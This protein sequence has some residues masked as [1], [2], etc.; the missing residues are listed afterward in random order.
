MSAPTTP[1][2]RP[3]SSGARPVA[4]A[5][6][7]V[8]TA[9]RPVA[10]ASRATTSAAPA[11]AVNYTRSTAAA[12]ATSSGPV[13]YTRATTSATSAAPA[14]VNYTRSTA[15]AAPANPQE[16]A[17][18]KVS[19]S[20]T[21][22]A[23]PA[24]PSGAVNY[25]RSTAS[26]APATS[27]EPA[28]ERVSYSR[29]TTST[30]SQEAPAREQVS[31]SRST[32]SAAPAAPAATYQRGGSPA[33]AGARPAPPAREQVSYSRSTS[34]APAAASGA[35][36]YSRATTSAAPAAA[37]GVA[38]YR[39]GGSPATASSQPGGA[40][41]APGRDKVSYSR[42]T[43]SAA[44]AAATGAASYQRGS[45]P[46]AAYQRGTTTQVR[47]GGSPAT[48][49]PLA[50][51][52]RTDPKV[53]EAFDKLAT[54]RGGEEPGLE[55]RSLR[56]ALRIVGI[57]TSVSEAI[58]MVQKYD[59]R[60]SGKLDL[61]DFSRLVAEF[62]AFDAAAG[63]P[64]SGAVPTGR[65]TPPTPSDWRTAPQRGPARSSGLR[66]DQPTGG[67]DDG[68]EPYDGPEVP[69]ELSSVA[70]SKLKPP[71][72]VDSHVDPPVLMPP[73][74]LAPPHGIALKRGRWG[75]RGGDGKNGGRKGDGKGA[76]QDWGG[77]EG[78][79][80]SRPDKW[81]A[82]TEDEAEAGVVRLLMEHAGGKTLHPS[83]RWVVR[84][85]RALELRYQ[86]AAREEGVQRFNLEVH[87]H[88]LAHD[89]GTHQD[90]LREA[91]LHR[92]E[93]ESD[94]ERA[95]DALRL[96]QDLATSLREHN[97]SLQ[98]ERE[99][100]LAD[101]E[102]AH[103]EVQAMRR[104]QGDLQSRW[105]QSAN[106]AGEWAQKAYESQAASRQAFAEANEARQAA[107]AV[108]RSMLN[109]QEYRLAEEAGYQMQT[110]VQLA[111]SKATITTV[112]EQP[113]AVDAWVPV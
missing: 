60:S 72:T 17:R 26:A 73:P 108:E 52:P 31:Y 5:A 25:S 41:E 15:S 93:A 107:A 22:S 86:A 30:T 65:V 50:Q 45:S 34:A 89:L 37:T 29:S 12:P 19:Y 44:P 80:F 2:A 3:P 14:A 35:V 79:V 111:P 95:R 53:E 66:G 68:R 38:T 64:P 40:E 69:P 106:E 18:E 43:A 33:P 47:R 82:D 61:T 103:G 32:A 20:R 1:M 51:Q 98:Q 81:A 112:Y 90:A 4:I 83:Q 84:A 87:A 71:D 77:G 57:E 105:Q 91:N 78:G 16:P 36:N 23:A 27:Q 10:T 46:A 110:I 109:A 42:S 99:A 100:L 8:A 56:E 75:S 11:G 88:Q 62:K 94:A 9:A 113:Q 54:S 13:A 85:M 24:A 39:R 58:A 21:T 49:Q 67:R 63:A 101:L 70:A 6:R 28:R 74:N 55:T 59:T 97:S 48:T 76:R 104:E 92:R 102:R 7:P 96:E